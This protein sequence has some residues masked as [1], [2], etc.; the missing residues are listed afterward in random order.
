MTTLIRK[1]KTLV[2]KRRDAAFVAL[3][4]WRK[5]NAKALKGWDTVAAVRK[6]RA[7]R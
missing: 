5:R 2:E 4:Q 7:S 6:I 3:E 1:K